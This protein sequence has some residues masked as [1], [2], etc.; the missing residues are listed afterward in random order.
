MK[1]GIR[2]LRREEESGRA[3][4]THRERKKERRKTQTKQGSEAS[5]ESER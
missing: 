2:E 1:E 4:T 5:K 3:I